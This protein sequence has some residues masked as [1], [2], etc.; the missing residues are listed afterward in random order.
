MLVLSRGEDERL[1]LTLPDGR[2]VTVL[3]VAVGRGRVRLGVDAPRDVKVLRAELL[4]GEPS[5]PAKE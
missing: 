3:V 1:L 5:P 2:T 4:D